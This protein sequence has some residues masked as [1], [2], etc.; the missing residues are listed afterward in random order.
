MGSSV[1]EKLKGRRC[2]NSLAPC[3]RALSS[4]KDWGPQRG[5]GGPAVRCRALLPSAGAAAC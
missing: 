4:A 3:D 5:C 2:G 1:W